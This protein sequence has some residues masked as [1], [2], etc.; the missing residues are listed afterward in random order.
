MPDMSPSQMD[1]RLTEL[2]GKLL[3]GSMTSAEKTEHH[4]LQMDRRNAVCTLPTL[5]EIRRDEKRKR[6]DQN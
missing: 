6:R 1:W 5:E 3:T 4:F 2:A